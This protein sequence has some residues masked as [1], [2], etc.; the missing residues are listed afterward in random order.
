[1]EGRPAQGPEE[2]CLECEKWWTFLILMFVGGFFGAFTYSIRG[3]VFCNAQTANF[4][5]SAVALGNGNWSEFFYY[6]IPMTAYFLGAFISESVPNYVRGHLHIRWDTLFLLIEMLAVVFLGLLP[7]T[8][9]YRITQVVINLVASMQYNTFRQTDGF[10][11]ATTFAT[12][13]IRQIGV[14]L[15]HELPFLRAPDGAH[16]KKLL[17]HLAMLLY[18]FAGTVIGTV[19][20]RLLLGKAIW[21]TILPLGAVFAALLRADLTTER[22]LLERPPAGHTFS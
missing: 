12:N 6:F 2:D 13:H 10:P 14:G 21:L 7:E 3:G 16:R 22:E 8:A 11:V 18:F 17:A 5:I 9:S 1:M 4:V 19:C 20:C 15:A